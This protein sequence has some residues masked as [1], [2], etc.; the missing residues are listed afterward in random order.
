MVRWLLMKRT[1][2]ST[3]NFSLPRPLR[4][5]LDKKVQRLGAY[6]ST[7]EYLRELVRRDLKRDAIAHVDELLLEGLAS[8]PSEPINEA[9]WEARRAELARHRRERAKKHRKSA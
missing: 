8:G 4:E 5:Q 3:M 1:K 2:V 7:S 9:W 6:S